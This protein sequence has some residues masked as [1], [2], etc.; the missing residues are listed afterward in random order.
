MVRSVCLSDTITGT[1]TK[2]S[3]PSLCRSIPFIRE[4]ESM[5][6]LQAFVFSIISSTPE[7]AP[8]A[9]PLANST[10]EKCTTAAT[11]VQSN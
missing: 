2:Q 6:Y 9:M 1:N 8:A 11:F 10:P 4:R 7:L 5:V 3:C